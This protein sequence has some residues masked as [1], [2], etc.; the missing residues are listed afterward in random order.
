MP[1]LTL[2]RDERLRLKSRS[3][4]LDPVVLLGANGLSDAAVKEIDRALDAHEL[5]KV[6]MPASERPQREQWFLEA[7]ERLGAARIQLIGRLMVLFRP[8]P[9]PADVKRNER[10]APHTRAGR[11]VPPPRPHRLRSC[12]S[13]PARSGSKRRSGRP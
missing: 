6:R 4:H 3:H 5:V 1:E 11:P 7:A 8:A 2:T 12:R 10:P 9:P 13:A